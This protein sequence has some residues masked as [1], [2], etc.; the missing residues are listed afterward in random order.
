MSCH[1]AVNA[2]LGSSLGLWAVFVSIVVAVPT[3]AS[4]APIV[5]TFVCV[6]CA[7]SCV[8]QSCLVLQIWGCTVIVLANFP[9]MR[10]LLSGVE[11]FTVLSFSQYTVT[12]IVGWC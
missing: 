11:P 10:L 5:P 7:Y 9:A 1:E 2:V 12:V 6:Y 3:T 4:T 8:C